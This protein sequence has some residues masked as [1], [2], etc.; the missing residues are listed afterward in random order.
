MR[1]PTRGGLATTLCEIAESSGVGI[2][3]DES[4]IPIRRSVASVCD[5]LGFDPVY[6]ANE[7]K[8]VIVAPG[9]AADR[10]VDALHSHELGR[11]AAVVGEV[12]AG[13]GVTMRTRVGGARP[14]VMLEGVQLP[15][16]C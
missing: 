8:A 3:I 6:M 16:I 12:V 13:G 4:A 7:G 1:A 9:D 15:R 2:T 11:D 5:I 10:V 14:V